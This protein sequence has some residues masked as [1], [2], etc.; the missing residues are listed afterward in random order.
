[1][2][3]IALYLFG[4][5][6]LCTLTGVSWRRAI[7]GAQCTQLRLHRLQLPLELPRQLGDAGH[8][9]FELPAGQGHGLAQAFAR[10]LDVARGAV[11]GAPQ[12]L[13]PRVLLAARTSSL[14]RSGAGPTTGGGLARVS[15]DEQPQGRRGLFQAEILLIHA[16]RA[17]ALVDVHHELLEGRKLPLGQLFAGEPQLRNGPDDQHLGL[18]ESLEQQAPGLGPLRVQEAERRRRSVGPAEDGALAVKLVQHLV[19]VQ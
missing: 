13:Q 19:V 15:A 18:Q 5:S 14:G 4:L 3:E 1:M 10:H 11:Q 2:R 8:L 6:T 12:L 7:R 17:T 9:N 16:T